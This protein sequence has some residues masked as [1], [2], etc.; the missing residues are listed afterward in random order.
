MLQVLTKNTG[1]FNSFYLR[2]QRGPD[3]G[4]SLATPVSSILDEK[5]EKRVKRALHCVICDHIISFQ[6]ALCERAGS[7]EH[8]Q[9]NPQ[10]LTFAFGCFAEAPGVVETSL[11]TQAFSWF[12]GYEWQ[13]IACASCLEHMG[14]RFSQPQDHFYGLL[15]EKIF[16]D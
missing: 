12:L 4:G 3:A 11:P 1:N 9:T 5:G 10:G 13:V 14:W 2:R 8:L 6:E 7:H 16:P 15:F